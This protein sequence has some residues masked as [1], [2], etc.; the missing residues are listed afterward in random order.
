MPAEPTILSEHLS[1]T[2]SLEV[3]DAPLS[4]S[5]APT[6]KITT[7]QT[8]SIIARHVE[9]DLGM[10]I[11]DVMFNASQ[12]GVEES[13]DQVMDTVQKLGAKSGAAKAV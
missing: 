12:T 9:N 6:A 13:M 4:N 8:E 11:K 3:A 2:K 5:L 7:T 1:I 10:S